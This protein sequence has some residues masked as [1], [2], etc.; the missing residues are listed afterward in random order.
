MTGEHFAKPMGHEDNQKSEYFYFIF[1]NLKADTSYSKDVSQC[2][3]HFSVKIRLF[4]QNSVGEWTQSLPGSLVPVHYVI[5]QVFGKEEI[6]AGIVRRRISP[7]IGCGDDDI[8]NTSSLRHCFVITAVR[9]HKNVIDR[10][11]RFLWC[12]SGL[13]LLSSKRSGS[14]E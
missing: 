14:L 1:M 4:W 10:G 9:R 11:V 3:L 13:L 7:V 5:S 2:S 6:D 12:L 8:I